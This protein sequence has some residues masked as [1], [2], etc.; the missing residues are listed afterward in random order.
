MNMR[1]S[2][3]FLMISKVRIKSLRYFF[4]NPDMPIHLRG[5]VRKFKEEIN[6]VRRELNRLEEVKILTTEKRGNRKYY[7]VNKEHP[8]FEVLLALMHKTFG[9]GGDLLKSISKLGDVKFILLT[10]SYTKGAAL[11]PHDV[12]LVVVGDVNIDLLSEIVGLAEKKL[13]KEVNYTVLTENDFDLRKKR[14]DSFVAELVMGD[15]ILV[16]GDKVQFIN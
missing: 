16:Y 14:R 10:S 6:A 8:Y 15:H 9:L 3:D 1:K 5:A 7:A 12:D 13:G 4:F 2:I 11:K